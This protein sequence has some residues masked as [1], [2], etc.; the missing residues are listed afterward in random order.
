MSMEETLSGAIGSSIR[1]Q[2]T[3]PANPTLTGTLFTVCPLSNVLA[4][5]TLGGTTGSFRIIPLNNITSFTLTAPP[6]ITNPLP[7]IQP[8]NI[9][10]LQA[11][12]RAALEKAREHAKKINP[13]A[14]KEAQE[15]FDAIARTLPTRWEKTDIVVMDQVVVKGPGY[16]VEDCRSGR[17]TQPHMLTRVKKVVDNERKRLAQKDT[18]GPKPVIPAVPAIPAF[19]GQRKGG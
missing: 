17:D 4:L 8:L 14:S 13:Q 9:N 3:N 1:I 16:K 5:S 12:A 10:A 19:S 15:L 2:T 6:S 18:K 11:R 7:P